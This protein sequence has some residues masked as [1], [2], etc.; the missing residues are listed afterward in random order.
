MRNFTLKTRNSV[1][2]T[3]NF[4]FKVMNLAGAWSESGL[5]LIFSALWAPI[6]ILAR[7]NSYADGSGE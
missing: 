6:L 1:S 4:V 2:K 7:L 3:R 5:S